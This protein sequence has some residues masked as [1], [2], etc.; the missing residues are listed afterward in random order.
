MG[1]SASSE[2]KSRKAHDLNRGLLK[3][4]QLRSKNT[5]TVH[6]RFGHPDLQK[7]PDNNTAELSAQP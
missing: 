1:E 4:R 6:P 7:Q 2:N 3:T 5:A